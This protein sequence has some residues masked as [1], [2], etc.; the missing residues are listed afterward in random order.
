MTAPLLRTKL[1][2]PPLRPSSVRRP[3]LI[4]RLNA[5]L[6]RKLTLISAPAGFGKTTLLSEWVQGLRQPVAW[7]S[8]DPSDSDVSRFWR[9]VIAALQSV[10]SGVGETAQAVLQGTQSQ[11]LVPDVLVT[12]L[13]NDIA[14]LAISLVLVLDDYHAIAELAVHE[15]L[16]FLLE[17]PPPQMHLVISTREDPPLPLPQ[18]RARGQVVE[19]RAGDL[20][21]TE[22]ETSALL[23]QA[24]GLG[25]AAEEIATLESRTEGWVAGLQLAALSLQGQADHTTF[26]RGFA[27]DDRHVMDYLV[28]EVLARQ[29]EVVQRFLLETSILDR[30]CGPLCDAVAY[31][32]PSAG[33]SQAI[34]ERLERANLFVVPLDNRRQWYRYH[35]LFADLLRYRLR[36]LMGADNLARLHR[37]ASEWHEHNGFADEAIAHALSASDPEHAADLLARHASEMMDHSETIALHGWLQAL[38]EETIRLRPWLCIYYAWVLVIVQHAASDIV[39]GWL[40]DAEQALAIQNASDAWR[41]AIRAESAVIRAYLARRLHEDDPR[42]ALAVW[43]HTLEHLPTQRS[44]VRTATLFNIGRCYLRVGDA[45]QASHAFEEAWHLCEATGQYYVGVLGACYRAYVARRQGQL[46]SAA[47]ICRRALAG[48][49]EP[50][51]QTGRPLPISGA[52]YASLGGILLE[53]GHLE[54]AGPLLAKGIEWIQGTGDL[55]LWVEGYA[56]LARLRQAEGNV[57][58]ALRL[59]GR[60][61]ELCPMPSPKAMPPR[62]VPGCG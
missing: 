54:E 52:L 29:P 33:V 2:I 57:V 12:A 40:Q 36:Q 53:W 4:E 30:L 44:G 56:T 60:V 51:E 47:A 38:P 48:L 22:P 9:Y 42:A 21:F 61:E 26:I 55:V 49:V 43:L 18:L 15:T 31:Q 50:A 37:Q 41:Q 5:G 23:N 8:L 20:R 28:D 34:L 39:E 19:L 7:V 14:A 13:V 45:V 32:D 16:R 3:H 17:H 35:H 46:H 11:R 59:L 24:M 58:E 10:D 6:D 62:S 27:G 1:Y 25:L